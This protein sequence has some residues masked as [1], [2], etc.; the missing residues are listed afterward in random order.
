MQNEFCYPVTQNTPCNHISRIMKE[1][2][3]PSPT[4]EPRKG[5]K[6]NAVSWE[7]MSQKGGH[8]ERTG[9]MG[10]RETGIN[11]FSASLGKL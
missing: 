3:D 7:P 5:I 2:I 8:H 4:D 9:G 6:N 1:E 10:A 11:H